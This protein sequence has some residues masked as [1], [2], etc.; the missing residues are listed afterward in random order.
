MSSLEPLSDRDRLLVEA[1]AVRLAQL[2]DE[3]HTQAHAGSLETHAYRTQAAH[4]H[5]HQG[6]ALVDA[7]T[8]AG[9]LGVSRGFVYAH[10]DELAAIRL[11]SGPKAPL[12]FDIEAAKRAM[13]CSIGRGSQAQI[14]Y[15]NGGSDAR[16]A[17]RQRRL[18]DRLPKPGSVLAVRGPGVDR[19]A[20][21]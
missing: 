8:L 11:G 16:P 10:R 17:R 18:P 4:A 12:R 7:G 19:E 2:L 9:L 6:P 13:R 5:A 1:I 3:R 15:E 20:S 14:A 21:S